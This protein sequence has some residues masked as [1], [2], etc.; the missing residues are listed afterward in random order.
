ML[1]CTTALVPRL[2]HLRLEG[3]QFFGDFSLSW[4]YFACL[5]AYVVL[6]QPRV[7]L[8]KQPL[9]IS[10]AAFLAFCAFYE[11]VLPF[12][13][14]DD[15]VRFG[16]S[17]LGG[18]LI[19]SLCTDR[20]AM[21]SALFGLLAGGLWFSIDVYNSS[22]DLLNQA[23][24]GS[25]AE[26]SSLRV[27]TMDALTIAANLNR[28]GFLCAEGAIVAISF[29]LFAQTLHRR[30]LFLGLSIPC[31]LGTFL[32]QSRS[33]VIT[34]VIACSLLVIVHRGRKVYVLAGSIVVAGLLL[35]IIPS[36]ALG[37]FAAASK[38][39]YGESQDARFRLYHA[40]WKTFPKYAFTGVGAGG[41]RAIW[42]VRNGFE[43]GGKLL[44]AHNSYLQV[45][46][47]W[48]ILGFALFVTFL[49]CAWRCLPSHRW[50]EPCPLA[51]FG[52]TVAMLIRLAFAHDFY[53]KDLG[54]LAGLLL[55][56]G[57]WL[58]PRL[59]HHSPWAASHSSYRKN[60][61]NSV[62]SL[63]HAHS[64]PTFRSLKS[65]TSSGPHDT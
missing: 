65:P 15:L 25:F 23:A 33:A 12:S 18:I 37:R 19:A 40:A 31:L 27:Q 34:V 5:A 39:Q 54:L 46:I 1:A 9:V 3:L 55:G 7:E 16:Q 51:L 26:A 57:T 60:T 61:R 58:W 14:L 29:A 20:M 50:S 36:S 53:V 38:T 45:L 30:I 64:H 41:F 62:G 4:V 59:K 6:R 56:S 17:I 35:L 2:D 47:N 52:L 10:A 63:R 48:G 43:T 42:G 24:V 44:G 13:R 49:W 21:K 8:L 22:Y 28:I 32:V 11:S